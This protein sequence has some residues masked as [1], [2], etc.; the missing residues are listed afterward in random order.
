[1]K[2][3]HQARAHDDQARFFEKFPP[4]SFFYGFIR[5]YPPAGKVPMIALDF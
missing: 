4:E 5:L 1:M 3:I 2:G